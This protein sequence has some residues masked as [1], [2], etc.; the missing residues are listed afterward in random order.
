MALQ[1]TGKKKVETARACGFHLFVVQTLTLPILSNC[2][3]LSIL[4]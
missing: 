4:M 1:V 2:G 3:M